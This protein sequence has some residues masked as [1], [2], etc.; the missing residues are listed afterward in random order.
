MKPPKEPVQIFICGAKDTRPSG[1]CVCGD[2]THGRCE[3]PL[4]GTMLGHNCNRWACFRHMV[5]VE[6]NRFMCQTHAAIWR[7]QK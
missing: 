7:T 5:Q 4:K 3:Y 6:P 2:R 1:Q